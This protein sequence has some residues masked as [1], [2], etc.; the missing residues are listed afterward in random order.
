[1]LHAM[2]RAALIA[3]FAAALPPVARAADDIIFAD[4]EGPDYGSWT[5][6]GTAFGDGPAAGTLPNQMPVSGFQGKRLVNSFVGGDGSTGKLTSPE[7]KIERKY[8]SF[9]IGGGGYEGKTC[10]TL[11][12]EGRAARTAT[13]PNVAGGGSEA[14]EPA[15]WDVSELRGKT[16]RLQ[17]VDEATG[18]WG[19]INLDYI[20]FT[21]SKPPSLVRDA[22]RELV[23]ERKYLQ[24]PVKRGARKH[25]LSIDL[26]GRTE[27]AFEI[28]LADE[29]PDWWAVLDISTW[30][31]QPL[32]VRADRM[33]DDSRALASLRQSNTI[34]PADELYREPL[35]PL[36]HFSARRGWLN[37]PNGLVFFEGEYHLFF[38]HNPYGWDWGNMHWGH[39]V[40]RDLMHWR[41]LGEALY[42][43]SLGPMFSGSAVVDWHNTSG[44]G[45]EGQPPL[46]LIYTAAGDPAVQCL[47]Y[48]TDRG[49]TFTKYA[50]NPV[51]KQLTPG[52]RD[53]KV[54]WHEPTRHWAMVLYVQR[55][56][57]PTIEFFTS[58]DLKQWTSQSTVEPF[59]ECPD[60]FEL[61]VAG[62]KEKR[63]VLTAA[64]SEYR[65]GTFDGRRFVPETPKLPGH[66]GR[67]FY[68]A[69][70]FSDIPAAD[71]RRIQIGWLQAPSPGMPF[72]QAMSV[73]LE[74]SLRDTS[75][76]IR[77]CWQPAREL[78][79]LR[80]K[81]HHVAA[82]ALQPGENALVDLAI[83]GPLEARIEFEPGEATEIALNLRGVPVV[84]DALRQEI[85]VNG[86][87]AP[88]PP[89]DGR[90]R[91]TM[92]LDKTSIEV[93]VADG[94]VYVPMPV[95]ADAGNSSLALTAQGGAGR[96]LSLDVHELSSL[97]T[98]PSM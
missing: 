20:V 98:E 38:Q 82:Q 51:L 28:E 30:K 54:I 13:G 80:V 97:W 50:G 84:Y 3:A 11:I 9:L 18:G 22:R 76:G 24:L 40:S 42:P 78:K 73:P 92:L 83:A 7:F 21:D 2:T 58:P 15:S 45:R 14:L 87:R 48:S 72:N 56:D 6:T 96:L 27:R 19:H 34:E 57:T 49:R 77:L 66:R 93:F 65:I 67:G 5:A 74:L 47:A 17:I 10:L 62:S 88:A 44:F 41:E 59:F 55:G 60:L 90:Q 39:A 1:M 95:I 91:W 89:V 35:R 16:A 63:W 37:D 70:T 29:G 26:A 43:D 79:E 33:R 69:Q 4:F 61:P 64:N 81:S 46:V 68:A 94:Q 85:V 53:P 86:H 31:G 36:L 32:T 75:E 25:R 23:A 12:V 71:A 8:I 52:N